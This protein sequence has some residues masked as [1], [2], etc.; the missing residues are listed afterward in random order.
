MKKIF[1]LFTAVLLV[2]GS[3]AFAQE[4]SASS[5]P[6]SDTTT[7]F[8]DRTTRVIKVED[9][10]GVY[11]PSAKNVTIELEYTP[12][13]GEVLVYYT[14]MKGSFDRGEAMNTIDAVLEDF[15]V[16]NK[17]RTK[18]VLQKKDKTR[19]YKDSRELSMTTYRR[20]AKFNR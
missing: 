15:A 7:N 10:Y 13:T 17:F 3:V 20:W 14:C 11:H 12:M 16:E 4:E 19:N 6:S 5:I 1:A 8:E 18:P 2:M 9:K